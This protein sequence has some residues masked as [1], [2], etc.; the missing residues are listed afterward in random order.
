MSARDA[1][2]AVV[3]ELLELLRALGEQSQRLVRAFA[4]QQ[5]L[6]PTDASA[7][8][9]VVEHEQRAQ[10][11]TTGELATAVGVTPGAATG[12]VDRL[13]AQGYVR[14]QQD[15]T[16]RRRVLLHLEAAGRDAAGLFFGRLAVHTRSLMAAYSAPQLETV[17]A[18]L[19]DFE[20]ACDTSLSPAP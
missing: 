20:A 2:D 17:M 19:R 15:A 6:H 1:E 9:W 4:V 11:L 3:D 14:R 16:D 7:L 13:I 5:G 12:I 8:F 10:P 18:F